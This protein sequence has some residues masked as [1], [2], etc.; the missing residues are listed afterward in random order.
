MYADGLI[1]VIE[2]VF[3]PFWK[4]PLDPLVYPAAFS[5]FCA[6][7]ALPVADTVSEATGALQAE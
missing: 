3:P 2:T 7:A 6:A 4:N 5:T 1:S